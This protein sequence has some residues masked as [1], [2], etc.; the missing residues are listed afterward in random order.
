MAGG[1]RALSVDAPAFAVAFGRALHRAGVPVTPDRSAR[2]AHA[3]HL[4]APLTRSRLYWAAHSSLASS[5]EEAEVLDR[6]FEAVFA[7]GGDP[8]AFRGAGA[9]SGAGRPAVHGPKEPGGGAPGGP[10]PP[11]FVTTVAGGGG[12]DVAGR[13]GRSA[14]LAAASEEERLAHRRFAD[15][16][17]EELAEVRRA[18]EAVVLA[19]PTRRSR[20]ERSGRRGERLDLRVTLRRSLR[21]GGDPARQARRRRRHRPRRLVLICDVSGSMAPYARAYLQLLQAAVRAGSAEAFVFATRLTRLTRALRGH[22]PD[23][24]LARALAAA[25]DWSGG[26]RIG[27]ALADF[28]NHHGRRGLARGA[29]VIILSD[30]WERAHPAPIGREMERLRRLAHRVVWVNPR[31]AAPGFEPLAGGMAAALPHVDALVSGHSL[32]ALDEVLEAIGEGEPGRR[33]RRGG[34]RGARRSRS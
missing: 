17:P 3:L 19:T 32:A 27:A 29:V 2:F 13:G 28:N 9:R 30:G 7:G 34:S 18:I 26:T 15:L 25:P 1:Q 24:A 10:A 16:A 22:S 23:N 11:P 12:E 21:T 6:V 33:L 5:R 31:A 4:L 20:R 14:V 8:A